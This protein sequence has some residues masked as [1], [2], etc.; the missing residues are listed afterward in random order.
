M[1]KQQEVIVSCNYHYSKPVT[2]EETERLLKEFN[3]LTASKKL[4]KKYNVKK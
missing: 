1:T 4:Q 3:L 2:E